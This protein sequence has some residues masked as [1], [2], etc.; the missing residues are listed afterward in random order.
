MKQPQPKR[1]IP[2]RRPRP[3]AVQALA[4]LAR[5]QL[6]T[7]GACLPLLEQDRDEDALHDFRVALRR[8]RTL[9]RLFDH[10]ADP[11]LAAR[12]DRALRWLTRSSGQRRDL[13]V[14][15][16]D[17]TLL[18]DRGALSAEAVVLLREPLRRERARA[19]RRL[20]ATLRGTRCRRTLA[21]TEQ[22]LTRHEAASAEMPLDLETAARRAGHKLRRRLRRAGRDGTLLRLHAARKAGKQFRYLLEVLPALGPRRI[23]R[24][25]VQRAI[26]E[27]KVLQEDLGAICDLGVQA[28]LCDE[29][30]A[31][32]RSLPGE[33]AAE[34][35]QL[36]SRLRAHA[37]EAAR[38]AAAD[39]TPMT[40]A[41]ADQPEAL[42]LRRAER[43]R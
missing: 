6:Q 18:A 5:A 13:D 43:G 35:A 37:A 19:Q 25:E 34:L 7:M 17:L 8:L 36:G 41:M 38:A 21:A 15:L 23:R 40:M 39:L 32:R 24:R 33:P 16:R 11:R 2:R 27:L 29:L 3:T 28:M 1:P 12:C 42:F 14:A 31:T 30:G 26:A 9:L 22:L 4:G 20:L 10:G